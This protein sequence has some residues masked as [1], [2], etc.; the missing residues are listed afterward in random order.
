MYLASMLRGCREFGKPASCH[1]FQ[2][3][4]KEKNGSNWLPSKVERIATRKRPNGDG[5]V[6]V[7]GRCMVHMAYTYIAIDIYVPTL[8]HMCAK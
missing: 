8:I 5:R 2:C 4:G 6:D 1:G 7:T 3:R